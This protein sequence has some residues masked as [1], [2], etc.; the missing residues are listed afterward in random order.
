MYTRDSMDIFK[1]LLSPESDRDDA[2]ESDFLGALKDIRV[3]ILQQE[4]AL[5]PDNWPYLFV[6]SDEQG[7]DF[8]LNAFDWCMSRGIGVA[9]NPQKQMP[10]YIFTYGMVWSYIKFGSLNPPLKLNTPGQA[11]IQTNDQL[12]AGPPTE[13]Y[14]PEQIRTVL[15]EFWV[16]QE[17][18]NMKVLVI[19][20]DNEHF[21]LCF[22]LESLGNPP[23]EEHQNIG[24]ALSWFLPNNYSILLISEK[25]LPPF[26]QLN[27]AKVNN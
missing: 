15:N 3:N 26:H 19:S 12:I 16:Q 9:L 17:V 6:Q 5:G 7:Q 14:L 22:S 11:V 21:D 24:E 10:D 13:E 2:W 23:K 4:P 27:F 8:L 1:H 20:K 25:G 18:A